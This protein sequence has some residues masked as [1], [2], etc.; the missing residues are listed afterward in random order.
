MIDVQSIP[1]EREL[2][3]VTDAAGGHNETGYGAKDNPLRLGGDFNA[4][5]SFLGDSVRLHL[6]AGEYRTRGLVNTGTL[7]LDGEPGTV[8]KLRDNCIDGENFPAVRMFTDGGLWADIFCLVG[9]TLDGNWRNQPGSQSGNFKIE[10]VSVQ[11]LVGRVANCTFRGWG[12]ASADYPTNNKL[13]AFPC[14]LTTFANGDKNLYYPAYANVSEPTT[15]LEI[16]DNVIEFGTFRD[17]GYCTAA[18]VRTSLG[19]SSGDRQPAGTRTTEA[20]LI[21]GNR[22][23]VPGGIALGGA[24]LDEVTFERNDV[25]GKCAFNLDTGGGWGVIIR[26]NRAFGVAQGPTL[27][28]SSG[29]DIW[30]ENNLMEMGEPFFNPVLGALEEAWGI[31]LAPGMDCTVIRNTVVASNSWPGQAFSGFDD[32]DS[33]RFVRFVGG[34]GSGSAEDLARWTALEAQLRGDLAKAAAR[35]ESLE[36]VINRYRTARAIAE[37]ARG[38]MFAEVGS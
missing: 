17:G 35:A 34:A 32:D 6:A 3:A 11:T 23:S 19:E 13:E 5:E 24:H 21:R 8:I 9:V 7:I 14:S 18:F 25:A 2:W 10:P 38:T 22:I 30:I 1:T 29:L 27:T 15:R 16:L 36:S 4:V 28:P 12:C 26:N 37:A 33:N 20:A 31:R